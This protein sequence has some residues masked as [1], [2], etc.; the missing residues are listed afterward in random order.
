M[1]LTE[2]R[3]SARLVD[4]FEDAF[5]VEEKFYRTRQAVLYV[6]KFLDVLTRFRVFGLH[7]LVLRTTFLVLAQEILSTEVVQA[8][9]ANV[10]TSTVMVPDLS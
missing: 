6:F 1:S 4:V 8:V 10:R 2:F 9:V 3:L 5:G 7:G